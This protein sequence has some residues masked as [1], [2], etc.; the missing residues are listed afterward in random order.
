M[1]N[2]GWCRD[3]MDQIIFCAMLMSSMNFTLLAEQ[4]GREL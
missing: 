3:E 1:A 2:D 4:Q